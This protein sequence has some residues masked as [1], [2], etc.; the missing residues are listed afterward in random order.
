MGYLAPRAPNYLQAVMLSQLCLEALARVSKT[1]QV[2]L[3][4]MCIFIVSIYAVYAGNV[5]AW[6]LHTY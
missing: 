5:M 2:P 4:I 1:N 6:S 3:L